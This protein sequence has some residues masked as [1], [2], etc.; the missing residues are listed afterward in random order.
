MSVNIANLQQQ[1]NSA[2]DKL[3]EASALVRQRQAEHQHAVNGENIARGIRDRGMHRDDLAQRYDVART[4]Q[5]AALDALREAQRDENARQ[6]VLEAAQ[7]R[8][9]AAQ[10]YGH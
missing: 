1:V 7:A 9:Q 4:E 6:R 8:L 3:D 2:Q 10:A 5:Y